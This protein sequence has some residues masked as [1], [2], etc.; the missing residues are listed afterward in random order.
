MER[1]DFDEK[2]DKIAVVIK[3]F[4]L[5]KSADGFLQKYNE[6]YIVSFAIDEKGAANPAIDVN[7]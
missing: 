7:I 2:T 6:P 5:L 1:E 3:E 4:T